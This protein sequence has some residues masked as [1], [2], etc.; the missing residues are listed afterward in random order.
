MCVWR[1]FLHRLRFRLGRKIR[2]QRFANENMH[3]FLRGGWDTQSDLTYPPPPVDR[4]PLTG[5]GLWSGRGVDHRRDVGDRPPPMEAV[6]SGQRSVAE[7]KRSPGLR[8]V[9]GRPARTTS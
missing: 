7:W 2:L 4:K 9:S 8:R 6:V 1:T 5:S 3:S